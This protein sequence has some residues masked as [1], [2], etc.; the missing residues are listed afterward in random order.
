MLG[1][2]YMNNDFLQPIYTENDL[3][4]YE[5]YINSTYFKQTTNKSFTLLLNSSIGKNIKIFIPVGNNLTL[6]QGKLLGV[7]DDYL[8][9]S[10]NRE[11]L[12]VKL[13]DI[14]FVSVM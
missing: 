7:Y 5:K 8:T 10:L 12:A 14:K 6:R 4:N 3:D 9:I 13:C 1:V 2:F 11:K